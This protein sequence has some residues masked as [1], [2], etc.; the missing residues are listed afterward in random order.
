M[1]LKGTKTFQHIEIVN[2]KINGYLLSLGC[3]C[4]SS[5]ANENEDKSKI[6]QPECGNFYQV[7]SEFQCDQGGT[8]IKIL[9]GICR[10]TI[11]GL[12]QIYM[13]NASDKTWINENH[14]V[15]ELPSRYDI[16]RKPIQI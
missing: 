3:P 14:L 4:H 15:E 1:P 13:L 9:Q 8:T 10:K 12:G 7:G 6:I 16:Q 5:S 11:L 2:S